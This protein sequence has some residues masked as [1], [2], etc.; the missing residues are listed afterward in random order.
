[1]W[2]AKLRKDLGAERIA[3]D[4]IFFIALPDFI[5]HF[6]CTTI[7]Y[8]NSKDSSGNSAKITALEHDFSMEAE[9]E[10]FY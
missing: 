3:D 1:M 6:R 5:E 9:S 7:S 8:E 10:N 4:G 2:T